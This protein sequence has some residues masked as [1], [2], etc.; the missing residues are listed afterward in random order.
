MKVL[1]NAEQKHVFLDNDFYSWQQL[2]DLLLAKTIFYFDDVNIRESYDTSL[3]YWNEYSEK[4][5]RVFL[6]NVE[7]IK[8][9]YNKQYGFYENVA[10]LKNGTKLHVKL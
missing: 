9:V 6:E 5:F 10:I 3:I 8:V 7:E 4:E 1:K 2:R